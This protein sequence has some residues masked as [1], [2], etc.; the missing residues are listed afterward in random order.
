[1]QSK[2]RNRNLSRMAFPPADSVSPTHKAVELSK[3]PQSCAIA[4][5]MWYV[6]TG[7]RVCMPEMLEPRW[8]LVSKAEK[9][10]CSKML[11]PYTSGKGVY[12]CAP[13]C[14]AL[15]V[16]E[17]VWGGDAVPMRYRPGSCVRASQ[18]ALRDG[19]AGCASPAGSGSHVG[20]EH[21]SPVCCGSG[22]GFRC[23]R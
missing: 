7:K 20:E 12:L 8:K 21:C 6:V 2:F 19:G 10:Q 16:T 18:L 13:V 11:P 5:G 1:M 22:H 3:Q 9:G 14:A 15:S 23:P 4:I 17:F